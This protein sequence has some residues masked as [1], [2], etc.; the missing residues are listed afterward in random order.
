MPQNSQEPRR[1]QLRGFKLQEGGS[2]SHA[3]EAADKDVLGAA[4]ALAK[5]PEAVLLA[6]CMGFEWKRAGEGPTKGEN[7]LRP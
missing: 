7:A 6:P 4:L 2:S 5:V 3:W 1:Q